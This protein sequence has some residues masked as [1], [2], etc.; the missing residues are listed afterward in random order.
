MQAIVGLIRRTHGSVSF[1]S[2]SLLNMKV[3]RR[4]VDIRRLRSTVANFDLW[5][6]V[7]A[8]LG[9]RWLRGTWARSHLSQDEYVA[10]F[11]A[12]TL[13]A[14]VADEATDEA[15]E[16]SSRWLDKQHLL[17]TW[18]SSRRSGRST[19]VKCRKV[20]EYLTTRAMRIL[21]VPARPRRQGP[22]PATRREFLEALPLIFP[23]HSWQLGVAGSF[24]WCVC[25][26]LC[27]VGSKIWERIG[28]A[29][30]CYR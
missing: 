19:D 14:F 9:S 4:L 3:M 21:Q 20:L 8:A 15:A 17:G 12:D 2:D 6:E 7:R 29:R 25:C 11:S 22:K 24:S 30:P 18:V 16:S 28:L 26:G 27:V 1:A 13:W 23:Q 5:L 10:Q